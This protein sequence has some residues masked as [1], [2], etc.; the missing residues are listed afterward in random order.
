MYVTRLLTSS[1]KS[2]V[3]TLQEIKEYTLEVNKSSG[4]KTIPQVSQKK[5]WRN[6]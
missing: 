5:Y 3:F 6:H 2:N 1:A 4:V